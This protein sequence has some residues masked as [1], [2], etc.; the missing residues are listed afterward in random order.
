MKLFEE[1]IFGTMQS[2]HDGVKM[3]VTICQNRSIVKVPVT[4]KVVIKGHEHSY[5]CICTTHYLQ[6]DWHGG[7]L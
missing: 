6:C 2:Y 5:V 1:G 3:G 7:L 4:G